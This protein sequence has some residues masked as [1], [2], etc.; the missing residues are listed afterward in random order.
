[1][2]ARPARPQPTAPR[3][4][5]PGQRPERAQDEIAHQQGPDAAERGQL[6]AALGGERGGGG[7]PRAMRPPRRAPR[8][9]GRGGA[10][11]SAR[12]RRRPRT[13]PRRAR[14]AAEATARRRSASR[15]RQTAASTMAPARPRSGESTSRRASWPGREAVQPEERHQEIDDVHERQFQR[16]AAHEPA[17]EMRGDARVEPRAEPGAERIGQHVHRAREAAGQEE[18]ERLQRGAGEERGADGG[19]VASSRRRGDAA[20][21]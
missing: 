15:W 10:A 12:A 7:R 17:V 19:P 11:G 3:P 20:M 16:E 18:L 1:M 5:R 14:P 21:R 13:S 8:R 9:R 2:S 4:R 6:E